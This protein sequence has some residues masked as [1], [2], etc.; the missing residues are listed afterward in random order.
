MKNNK[1]E[2]KVARYIINGLSELQANS[3]KLKKDKYLGTQ[4]FKG[5]S[6]VSKHKTKILSILD[7]KWIIITG[8][9]RGRSIHPTSQLM[10]ATIQD[11]IDESLRIIKSLE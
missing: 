3:N 5:E 6:I 1:E 10:S 2:N 7:G 8:I 4:I 9:G 11:I